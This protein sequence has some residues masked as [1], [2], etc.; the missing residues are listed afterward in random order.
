M[1][2]KPL[3]AFASLLIFSLGTNAVGAQ[4]VEIKL[5]SGPKI[6]GE[7]IS[8]DAS[9]VSV[10]TTTIGKTGRSMSMTAEYKRSEI[11]EL[12][13]LA[14]PEQTYAKRATLA[15]TADEHGALSTWCRENA[16]LDHA[17]EQAKLALALEH[18]HAASA[19]LMID[20][21]WIETDGKWIKETDW[22]ASQGKVRYQGTIM[23]LEEAKAAKGLEKQQQGLKE[24]QQSIDDKTAALAKLDRQIEELPK[25]P[26]QIEVEMAKDTA[27]IAKAQA[28][29]QRVAEAKTAFDAAEAA[30]QK[31]Q[32]SLPTSIGAG[33]KQ[34]V[35]TTRLMPLI[36]ASEAAQKAYN[37]VRRSV[38]AADAELVRLKNHQTALQ[39]ETKSLDKKAL[40][41]TAKREA[42]DKDLEKAKADL[43]AMSGAPAAPKPSAPSEKTVK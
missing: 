12:T 37:D 38:G 29:T 35:D 23:T 36:A 21:G 3:I 15:K 27:A 8:E 4:Q 43:A 31:A 26:A 9:K 19:K 7:L 18:E 40:D 32:G 13:H 28:V 5:R 30:V 41:L 16:M 25:R 20:L 1:K 34:V 17:V 10:K 6:I 2:T 42:L 11:V 33:G 14:D 24:A 22:L 39:A